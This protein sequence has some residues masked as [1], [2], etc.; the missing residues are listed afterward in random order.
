MSLVQSPSL[1]TRTSFSTSL[2]FSYTFSSTRHSHSSS[3]SSASSFYSEQ[4]DTMPAIRTGRTPAAR[5]AAANK[6]RKETRKR[7]NW[8][9][10]VDEVPLPE[11][12]TVTIEESITTLRELGISDTITPRLTNVVATVDTACCLELD[13]IVKYARN[14]EYNPKRIKAVIMR[15]REPRSTALIFSTGKIVCVGNKSFEAARLASRKFVRII[16]KL[17]YAV[18]FENFKVQNIVASVGIDKL[19]RLE[20]LAFD[21]H[22]FTHWEAEIFPGLIYTMREL[23]MK[24]LVFASGKIVFTGAKHEQYIYQAWAK[25]YPA[26]LQYAMEKPPKGEEP[27]RSSKRKRK[28]KA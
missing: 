22:L 3:V 24:I 13:N 2:P 16:Q 9:H 21:H 10:D 5:L 1:S 20:G 27:Q 23:R 15:I 25:L 11:E 8:G 6:R 26:L 28:A 12:P 7:R 19:I 4:L 18:K 17:G 14:A